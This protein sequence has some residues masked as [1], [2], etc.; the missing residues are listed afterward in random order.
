MTEVTPTTVIALG[1]CDHGDD[2][3]ALV[4]ADELRRRLPQY[5]TLITSPFSDRTLHE[6]CRRHDRVF[7]IDAMP[8]GTTPGSIRRIDPRT[9]ELPAHRRGPSDVDLA[10]VVTMVRTDD[11]GTD[12]LVVYGIEG[13]WSTP[14]AG[15]SPEVAAA[16]HDLAERILDAV[17]P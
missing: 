15:I 2:A 6:V 10:D 4:V 5:V 8:P 1:R 13:R 9:D 17:Q 16:A 3:A 14:Q 7:V 12:A 11:P